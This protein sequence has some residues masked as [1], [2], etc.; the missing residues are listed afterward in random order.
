MS[1]LGHVGSM[2]DPVGEFFLQSGSMLTSQ[3]INFV[4]SQ[5]R[6]NRGFLLDKLVY[7]I[8]ALST[9]SRLET[10]NLCKSVSS[11]IP[12]LDLPSRSP[13]HG[14]QEYQLE[15]L[16]NLL[17]SRRVACV[18]RKMRSVERDNNKDTTAELVKRQ[19][20]STFAASSD[21]LHAFSNLSYTAV[22]LR[23]LKN[24]HYSLDVQLG[25]DAQDT[26]VLDNDGET[27][28]VSEGTSDG[29]NIEFDVIGLDDHPHPAALFV[30]SPRALHL[31]YLGTVTPSSTSASTSTSTGTV[32]ICPR[33]YP[34]GASVISRLGGAIPYVIMSV[35]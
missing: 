21:Q 34:V 8:A 29:E 31:S 27:Y 24:G 3:D 12:Q 26:L 2:W 22:A 32:Q 19:S 16:R 1:L 6:G 20:S 9:F 33:P 14:I 28:Y 18:F 13:H 23:D 30:D 7:T 17:C 10:S 5:W 4:E 15:N 11:D 25:G 35:L